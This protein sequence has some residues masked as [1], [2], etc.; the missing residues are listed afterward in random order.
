MLNEIVRSRAAR[1]AFS[2]RALDFN[3]VFKR[4]SVELRPSLT[5][6]GDV[7]EEVGESCAKATQPGRSITTGRAP[8]D[9]FN[10]IEAQDKE[11][12]PSCA[13]EP[14]ATST[15]R[16]K[17]V[18]GWIIDPSAARSG[19]PGDYELGSL[20]ESIVAIVSVP[21]WW[22]A[23]KVVVDRTWLNSDGAPGPSLPPKSFL[24][25]LPHRSELVDSLLVARRGPVI[26]DTDCGEGVESGRGR[27]D[28]GNASTPADTQEATNP[29]C[30][31]KPSCPPKLRTEGAAASI[32]IT[33]QRLWRNT[34]VTIGGRKA[35][36]VEVLP[37]MDGIIAQ[38]DGPATTVRGKLRVW[39]SEG[40]TESDVIASLE[41]PQNCP[42]ESAPSK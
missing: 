32:L 16:P 26:T 2:D 40:M 6:F 24:V 5:T 29:P 18:I 12:V 3:S 31:L 13:S 23:L 37:N 1:V 4:E 22:T 21:A 20:A 17:P 30:I 15:G 38:F 25:D 41:A 28:D 39:T 19:G 8:L 34:A 42:A 33:G 9:Q 14:E 35:I 36:K 7:E 10:S 27:V 11:A